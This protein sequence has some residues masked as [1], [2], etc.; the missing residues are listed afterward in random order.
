VLS[1]LLMLCFNPAHAQTITGNISGSI[2]DSSGAVIPNA[3][4]VATNVAN[5]FVFKTTSNETGEYRLRFLPVGQYK[6]EVSASGFQKQ[7]FGPFALEIGQNAKVDGVL[8]VGSATTN[9]EVMSSYAPIL[10]TEDN[11]IATT[12]SNNTIDSMPLNG[13]NF[14]SLTIFLPGSIMTNPSGM[15]GSNAYERSTG[16]SGQTSVNGNRN[17][18]NNYYLDGIEINETINNAIGYNPAPDALGEVKV[19]SANAPAEYGNVN[20]GD[21]IAV[22]K[23]GSNQWHGSAYWYLENDQLDANTWANKHHTAGEIL[24]KTK[25]TR[26]TFGGTVGGPIIKN[27]LFFFADYEGFRYPTAGSDSAS[28]ATSKMRSG[29]FSEIS[30]Q[31]YDNSNN[32]TGSPAAYTNNKIAVVNPV[33]TYLFAHTDLYPL[34]NTTPISGVIYN[35]YTGTTK[36]KVRNDQGDIRIDWKPNQADTLMV[37]YL[38]GESSDTT[39]KAVL[40]ITFPGAGSYPTKGIAINEVH[41]FSASLVNEL[42]AGFTRVHWD[43]GEPTD[44]TGVFGTSGNSILGIAASQPFQGFTGINFGCNG[45]GGC[46]SSDVPT[47]LGNDAGGTKITDNTF[48]YGDNLTWL[49]GHHTFKGG[50]EITRYQQN[51]YYPGNFGANG[52]FQYYPE[53]TMNV[54]TTEL[55]PAGYELADFA[56]DAAGFIGQG[57][58]DSNGDVTGGN[59]QRQYRAG[60]FAQDDWKVTNNLTLN[61]GV[62]YEYDQPIYEVHDKEA[63]INFATKSIIYAGQNGNSRALYDATYSNFM[64]RI[65][66]NY[67]PNSKVVVRGGYGI[68]TYLEGTGANLRLTYN[69]PYWNEVSGTFTEPTTTSA[70]TFFK[71]EDGFSSGSSDTLAGSTYRAW[72]KVKP[73]VVTEWNLATEYAITGSTN[74]TVAYVGEVGQHLIQAVAY[75]QLTTPCAINGS[76]AAGA[77]A[78]ATSDACAAVDPSPFYDIVGQ[79]GSVVGTTSEGAMNYHALQASLRQHTSKGLEYTINYTWSH[80]MTNSVGFFGVDS[81][82]GSSAYAQNA[83]DNRAEYGPAGMDIR[84]AINGNAAYELPFGRGRMF[85]GHWNRVL[86]EAAGGWKLAMTGI[87][88][89]GFPVTISGTDNSVTGAKASRPNHYR[90]INVVNRSV[91]HWFGTDSSITACTTRGENDGTCAYG[92][93]A[94]G[95]FGTTRPGTE[96]APGFMQFDLSAYKDFTIWRDHK[97]TFRA[98][99]FNAFNISSYGNPDAGYADSNFGQITSV[100]SVPRQFQLAAK[101]TF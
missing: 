94:Y 35:N 82:T 11:T 55:K 72:Y 16:Q 91:D 81:V 2:T 44:S 90:K 10:N 26:P 18:T 21:L 47:N 62:R 88:Y 89:S 3:Q 83:Y 27:K 19:I 92:N 49:H 39:T 65:G 96:R 78:G 77:A 15:T 85:G 46:N 5:G 53:F 14:S 93:T 30:S 61:I 100:R 28:V 37:R 67:Q 57:G 42:R 7:V 4:V 41:Q 69:K 63:N 1:V 23:A 45:L 86:D 36:K 8:N 98:D 40:P 80:A 84:H 6:V 64:P 9:V 52:Y 87:H 71:V 48:Q 43:Q 17:Q 31:L 20:G 50:V 25:Y 75:N 51:N 68:T 59:G 32:A 66:F 33:A 74:L 99:A 56:L 34:P 101:Y 22:T 95:T 70:G 76:Y 38:Q 60:Y 24:A 12:L 29:D 73:S 54:A 58:L 97:L 79:N 13:R